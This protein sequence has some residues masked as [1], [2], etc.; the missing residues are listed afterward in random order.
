LLVVEDGPANDDHWTEYLDGVPSAQQARWMHLYKKVLAV[1][2]GGRVLPPSNDLSQQLADCLKGAETYY[3]LTFD[4]P[5]ATHADEYHSLK[6]ELGQPGLT[7][8]TS[9]GYYNQPFYGDPPNPAIRP[10]T[11]SQL[12]ELL[13]SHRGS[14]AAEQLLTLALIERLS[15][16]EVPS[17]SAEAP[18]KKLRESLEMLAA[19]S[20]FLDPPSSQAISDRSPSPAEQQ[21]LLASATDYLSQI[22]PRLPDFFAIRTA[23]Y[24]RE[25]A[26]YPGMAATIAEPLH[27]EQRSSSTVLYRQ[28][29]PGV[30]STIWSRRTG[31]SGTRVCVEAR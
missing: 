10:V 31:A 15:D 1:Q 27:P 29:V 18:K 23:V 12:E 14:V 24:Y 2:S 16:A 21:R 9:S 11:V 13:Q 28:G 30:F 4:P 6:V 19:E 25:V 8:R 26:A 22:I 3:T 5:L 7:A 17:L 20:A